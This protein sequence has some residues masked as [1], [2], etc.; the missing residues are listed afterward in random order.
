MMTGVL[1]ANATNPSFEQVMSKLMEIASQEARV[2]ETDGSNLPQVHAYNCLKEIFKSSYLTAIGN[3]S[4]KFLPQCLELAANGLK[5]ELWAIRN[6]GLI[7]LRSLIDCLFGSHQSKATM[8]AGWDGKANRIAYHRYPSLPTTLLHLLKSGHQMM[9]SIAASSAAAESV[10]PAL[11]IIRRAGPPEVLRDELQIHIA[12]YLASPV[13]HVREIAART[14]CSC[15]LH[16]QWLDTITSLA[17]ESVR[18][19]IGNVQNHVH[20]V[21]LALKYIIERLNEVMPEQLQ[22]KAHRTDELDINA[23]ENAEDIPKLSGFLIEYW[24]AIQNLDSPEIPAAYLE[25]ANLVR[26][27]PRP[28]AVD[29]LQLEFPAFNKREGALLRAQR[30]I[31]EV[32]S[33]AEGSGQIEDLNTL[34]L[35]KTMGVNTIVAGLETIPKLWDTSRLSGQDVNHF[36]NLYRDVCLKI[37]PAEPRVI[38]LQNLTDILDQILKSGNLDLVSPDLLSQIWNSLPLSS[39]NPALANAII[40]ISGCITG[41]LSKSQAITAEGIKNWGHMVADAGLDD[42]VRLSKKHL[43]IISV[44]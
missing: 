28:G 4:E 43:F 17:A 12:K 21:L 26:V 37:G 9:A 1:S 24:R 27:L 8:E 16:A 3:K 30:V 35:G 23:N 18:S 44:C 39:L 40:R 32:H 2:T 7:L 15:L 36:C 11:D 33:I 42:K 38:A 10:F 31:H 34:L 14:L 29:R 13:W 5:S 6:C 19:Q 25:V 22:R 20:G 41:I